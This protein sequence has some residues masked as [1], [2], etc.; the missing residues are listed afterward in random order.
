MKSE[1]FVLQNFS[2]QQ[3]PLLNNVVLKS[4]DAIEDYLSFGISEVQNRYN[5]L[6]V[7]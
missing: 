1:N 6:T 2:S 4:V 3:M 5:G 7:G